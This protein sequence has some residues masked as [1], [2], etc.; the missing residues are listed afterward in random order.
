MKT[1]QPYDLVKVNRNCVNSF[2]N[3]CSA[4]GI[5]WHVSNSKISQMTFRVLIT[6]SSKAYFV[7]TLSKKGFWISKS[8]LKV[9]KENIEENERPEYNND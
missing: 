6:T 8:I 4:L 1:I 3:E 2:R 5:D 7:D 9:V